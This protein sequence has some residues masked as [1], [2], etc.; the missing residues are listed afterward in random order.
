MLHL[1]TNKRIGFESA[2][3]ESKDQWRIAQ[4]PKIPF[5]LVASYL[6]YYGKL[7]RLLAGRMAGRVQNSSI[8]IT[9]TLA[10]TQKTSNKK[11][12]HTLTFVV[13]NSVADFGHMV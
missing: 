6:K 13:S 5:V 2:K 4:L 10:I 8:H 12:A 9:K 11:R 1:H 3:P 7:H